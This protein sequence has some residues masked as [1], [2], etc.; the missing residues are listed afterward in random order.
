MNELQIAKV[1]KVKQESKAESNISIY[2]YLEI[3][4]T[5]RFITSSKKERK[6]P[7]MR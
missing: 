3:P 6:R 7:S 2:I 5:H 4:Q 1:A